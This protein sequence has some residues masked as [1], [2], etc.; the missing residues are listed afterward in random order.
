MAL[1][2][3]GDALGWLFWPLAALCIWVFIIPHG[4]STNN[5]DISGDAG[6]EAAREIPDIYWYMQFPLDVESGDINAVKQGLAAGADVNAKDGR[7]RTPLYLAA[8]GH[9]KEIVELLIANGADVNAKDEDGRT[10]LH[11]LAEHY[12]NFGFDYGMVPLNPGRASTKEIC[13]LL[14]AEGADEN[15]KD[16]WGKTP[17][18]LV[19]KETQRQYQDALAGRRARIV[20]QQDAARKKEERARFRERQYQADRIERRNRSTYMTARYGTQAEGTWR[21]RVRESAGRDPFDREVR[22]FRRS[23]DSPRRPPRRSSYPGERGRFVP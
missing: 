15:A 18:G 3:A 6:Q 22:A 7:G 23:E 17:R 10:P 20:A 1:D 19:I 5:N 13:Q 8:T 12:N 2:E 11:D 4:P 21:A 14:I 9:R 16:L